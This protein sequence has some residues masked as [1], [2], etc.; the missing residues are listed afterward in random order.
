AVTVAP[1]SDSPLSDSPLSRMEINTQKNK[2]PEG[3]G[4]REGVRET[5]TDRHGDR[6]GAS[7][8]AVSP[9]DPLPPDLRAAAELIGLRGLDIDDAWL[10]FAGRYTG[11]IIPVEGWWQTWCARE[12][13][14]DRSRVRMAQGTPRTVPMQRPPSTGRTWQSGTGGE[15]AGEAIHVQDA[16]I[17]RAWQSGTGAVEK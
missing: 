16:P 10:A 13:K 17:V 1:L 2:S 4:V 5:V 6:H 15:R 7:S 9:S 11:Q 8:R 3:E 12:R 14:Y